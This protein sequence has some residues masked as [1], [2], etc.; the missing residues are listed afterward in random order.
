VKQ[1]PPATILEFLERIGVR[2]SLNLYG[3]V[4]EL[5]PP[6]L[7]GL[8]T[9]V[10]E[11]LPQIKAELQRRPLLSKRRGSAGPAAIRPPAPG[12]RINQIR[13][14]HFFRGMNL[15]EI[16]QA[17][18]EHEPQWVGLGWAKRQRDGRRFAALKLLQLSAGP[19][20]ANGKGT[21]KTKERNHAGAVT[22]EE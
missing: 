11:C 19:S 22:E 8:A 9:Y 5:Y 7:C 4:S 2:L 21:S 15:V 1:Q 3:E 13:I 16:Y 17:P 6:E 14:T 18:K 10:R 20:P 12:P